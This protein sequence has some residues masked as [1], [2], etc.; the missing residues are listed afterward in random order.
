MIAGE[1]GREADFRCTIKHCN[2]P[3]KELTFE[4]AA[5]FVRL[6]ARC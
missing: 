1:G 2:L 3:A 6:K 5:G 4:A